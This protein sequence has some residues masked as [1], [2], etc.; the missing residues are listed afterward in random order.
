MDD[1]TKPA[2]SMVCRYMHNPGKSHWQ[3]V[4]WILRYIFGTM[5]VG[6]V[7][8]QE[9]TSQCVVGYVDSDYAGDLDISRSTTAYVFTL[10]SGPV[11]WKLNLDHTIALLTT[12]AEYMAVTEGAKEEV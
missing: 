8:Q 12:E 6:L 5:D 1:K 2:L 7:F 4:K 9:K 10:A 11:S 3:A